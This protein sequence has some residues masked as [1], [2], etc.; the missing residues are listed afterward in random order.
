M[1][2]LPDALATRTI[3]IHMR[4][5]TADEHKED[6]RYR[7]HPKEAEPIFLV[8]TQW[9]A[10][11]GIDITL[12]G[13]REPVMPP[14]IRDRSADIWEPLLIVAQAAGGEWPKRARAAAVA[15]TGATRE[16]VTSSGRELLAHC[17]EEF[18]AADKIHTAELCR[19]LNQREDSPWVEINKGK[20]INGRI[21]ASMLKPYGVKPA[22]G[23]VKI[24]GVVLKG[25]YKADFD[26]A[27]KRY[28]LPTVPGDT[29]DTGDTNLS[30]KDNSV[31]PVSPVSP[32]KANGVEHPNFGKPRSSKAEVVRLT[33]ELLD[34][35]NKKGDR[36]AH[37][38][39]GV[40][41][42]RPRELRIQR[43][44]SLCR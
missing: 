44:F 40:R 21:L 2:T 32:S 29:A 38:D 33:A 19:R 34:T 36:G 10:G 6:F 28:P 25:Y 7:H 41:Q 12:N 13:Y 35:L 9:C 8:L 5:R 11:L 20:P 1:R 43:K 23:G 42:T 22:P 18:K 4:P 30:N 39:T 26:E 24:S 27:S 15:L 37:A 17:R 14:G 31:S 3:F 16:D